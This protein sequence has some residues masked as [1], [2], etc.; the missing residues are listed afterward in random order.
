M[1][2]KTDGEKLWE[3]LE[4][5]NKNT[6]DGTHVNILKECWKDY[7]WDERNHLRGLLLANNN[8]LI[9]INGSWEF[10]LAAGGMIAKKE[11]FSDNGTY[12]KP[13]S[14]I[15]ILDSPDKLD[16]S[17]AIKLFERQKNKI[18]KDIIIKDEFWRAETSQ[19]VEKYI[20]KASQAY[21]YI[22]GHSFRPNGTE[23]D[24]GQRERGRWMVE[25]SKASH[26]ACCGK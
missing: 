24:A 3:T 5:L 12:N 2:D 8:D 25:Y 26:G 11:Y 10:R 16:Y 14:S 19:L 21:I 15:T 1:S 20:G 22:S 9:N 4:Y 23:T 7:S 17:L 13:I 6:V 18:D